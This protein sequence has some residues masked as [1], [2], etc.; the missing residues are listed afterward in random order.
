MQMGIYHKTRIREDN[1]GI[2]YIALRATVAE[3]GYATVS[4]S[5]MAVKRDSS[6]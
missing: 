3:G 4:S 5:N 2:M 6:L 1:A